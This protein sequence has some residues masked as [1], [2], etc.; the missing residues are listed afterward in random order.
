LKLEVN[1]VNPLDD[2]RWEALAEHHPQSSAF[3]TVGWLRALAQTYGYRPLVLTTARAGESLNNGLLLC[4]VKSW[5]TGKRLVSLPFADHCELLL[6]GPQQAAEFGKWLQAESA[7]WDYIEL[8]TRSQATL[9]GAEN[10]QRYWFHELDLA[11]SLE[12]LFQSLH[13]S[14]IQRKVRRAEKEGLSYE[15][16]R[17]PHLIEE[18][19]RLLLMTRRRHRLFPQPRNWFT[20]LTACLGDKLQVRIARKDGAPIAAMIT[21]KHRAT[22]IYKYGCSDER[23][24]QL[25][26]MA[27]LFWKLIEESKA[28]G[29]AIIDF[30]RSDGDNPGLVIFKDRFG[31][32]RTELVYQ[33]YRNVEARKSAGIGGAR[34]MRRVCSLLPDSLLTI[35]GRLLYRHLG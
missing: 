2:E 35:S 21:L 4:P 32:R 29:A 33:R 30:G 3:H 24:H 1:L 17:S 11:P 31:T 26:G 23:W 25:G 12:Q 15:A 13:K 7:A 14:S 22:V 18:F 28:A 19:Y 16:G 5:L 8:R 9:P 20:N 34:M 27:F 6:E 10:G